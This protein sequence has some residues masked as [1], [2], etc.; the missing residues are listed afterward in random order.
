MG[1]VQTVAVPV[2]G[3]KGWYNANVNGQDTIV[4]MRKMYQV[5]PTNWPEGKEKPTH[6]YM[7]GSE[8]EQN[9]QKEL[10]K[11]KDPCEK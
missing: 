2:P 8:V 1:K 7:T 5:T 4:F 10:T 11:P 9:I 6:S 3:Y